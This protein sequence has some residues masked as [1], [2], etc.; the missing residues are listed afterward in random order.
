[1]TLFGC[2]CSIIVIYSLLDLYKPVIT[3]DDTTP[4]QTEE[5]TVVKT[6]TVEITLPQET[7]IKHEFEPI[8]MLEPLSESMVERITGHSY[9]LNEYIDLTDLHYVTVSYYNYDLE[10][11]IGEL[12]VNR[13]ISKDI[14]LIFKDLYKVKYPIYN[15]QLVDDFDADDDKSMRAN[16]TSAFNFRTISGSTKLSYHAFGLAIDINP[17]QNP[18]VNGD[19]FVPENG[20]AYLDRSQNATGMIIKDDPCYEAFTSRGWQWGGDWT[21][22]KDYQHFEKKLDMK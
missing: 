10:P 19:Y 18:F 17:V 20:E 14:I 15:I 4:L 16:N 5:K 3:I 12:I 11:Q 6:E 2:L 7:T 22:P 8:F 13:R 9:Q 21:S 1:M